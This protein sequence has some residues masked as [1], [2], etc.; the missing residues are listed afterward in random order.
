M[1]VI[2]LYSGDVPERKEYE[3]LIG[4][5][6]T[7][8]NHNHL[9]HD[10]TQPFL[11]AD[12]T[13]D[14]F[15]TEDVFEH[16]P[17]EKLAPV[18]NEIYRVLKPGGL[19]RLS[20]P[21]YGCDVLQNRSIKDERGEIVFDPGGGGT[22]DSP[23]HVWFPR[24]DTV[25]QL[26]TKTKFHTSGTIELLHYYNKDGTFVAK[27]IDYSKGP[28]MRTPDFDQRVKKPYRPMSLVIDLTKGRKALSGTKSI[29]CT[30]KTRK[31]EE[32]KFSFVMIVLNGMP[33][34]E[35]ALK[36]IYDFAH[37]IIIVEGS[38]E[39]CM[40]A[41]DPDGSST[42]GTVE[43]ITS[44]SDRQNKIKLIQG[45]WPEKCEMQNEAL[46][47]V[48]GDYVWLIDSDEVYKREDLEKIK[49]IIKA[50]PTVTQ[51]DFIP[52]NFW[53]GLDYIFVS[54]KFYEEPHHYRRLFKYKPGAV[55]T[56]H[57]PPTMFWPNS[58]LST[59]QMNLIDGLQTRQRGIILYHYSYVLERQVAQKMEY[60]R[61]C[62]LK[63]DR[64]SIDRDTWYNECFLR[65]NEQNRKQIEN[66]Y[67]VWLGDKN[68]HIEPFKGT[69]P[70]VM[71]EYARTHDRNGGA[72]PRPPVMQNL[73][74]A[75][76]E[77]KNRFPNEHLEMIETGTIR[78]FHAA[79][80]STY[81][82]SE[83]LGSQGRLTSVDISPDSIRIS[84]NFCW[85]APNIEWIQSDSVTYL[86]KLKDKKFH[87]AFLDSVNQKDFIFEEF[88]LMI[89]MM[90][91][92]SILIIDDSGI[93]NDGCSI[94]NGV[95]AQKGHEVWC[96]L[97]SCG[98]KFNIFQVPN[99]PG[100]QLKIGLGKENL[101]VIKNKLRQYDEDRFIPESCNLPANTQSGR[102]LQ[103]EPIIHFVYSGDPYDDNAIR[104]PRTITNKLFRFLKQRAEVKY[105]DWADKTSKVDVKLNDIIL[106]HPNPEEGT[107]IRRLFEKPCAAKYLIWPFHTRIPEINR[108]AKDVADVADKL[109]VISGPHWIETIDQTEYACW[110]EKI[111]R[112]DNAIDAEIFPLLKKNFNPVSKRGLF[113]FGRTG[114]E[115][116]T[117]QLFKLL[118][119]TDYPMVVA[120][121]YSHKDLQIIK[122]RPNTHIL[123]RIDWR[124]PQTTTFILN[125][126][127]FFVNMSVSDASP[128]TLLESM[129]LGLIPVTTPQCGYYYN[130]FLLLS[131]SQQEHNLQILHQAQ[132]L[133]D[134]KLRELQAQNRR[135]IE[136]EHSW[137][138]F[139]QTVWQNIK[140]T[141]KLTSKVG[142]RQNDEEYVKYNFNDGKNKKRVLIVRSDSIGDFVIFGG[143]LPYY[144][145]I[146]PNAQITIVVSESVAKLAEACLFIDEVITF[147][148]GKI[149][150][151]PNYAAEFINYVRDKQFDVAIC[152]A[153]SRDKVSEFIA[154][155]SG[156]V[157]KITC[158]GDTANLPADIIKANNAHYTK[159]VPM[160]EGIALETFRNE[161]F[162]KG[163]DVELDGPYRPTVWVTQADREVAE[164]LLN[165]RGIK[166]PIVIIPFVQLDI[167]NWPVKNWAKLISMYPDIPVIICG[168]AKDKPAAE[169]I[170][171]FANHPNIHN[172]CGLTTVRQ[173]AALI[174]KSRLS[175]SSESGAAHISAAANRP[176][177]VLIGGGHFGR[178]M[179]YSSQTKLVYNKMDCYNCNW[180]CKYGQDISCIATISVDMVERAV[181]EVFG[182]IRPVPVFDNNKVIIQA[183]KDIADKSDFLVSAIV[184]TYNSEKFIRGCLED[185]E[186]QTIADKLE[187]IVINSGS[188]ENE[189]TI[190][191]E[192]QQRYDNIKYIK[193]E[194]REG[195]YVAWNRAVQVAR[196]TF[197]TNANTDDRHR[198][199]ALEIMAE[200]LLAN[201][202]VALA[203]GD[204]ICTDTP[205]GTF[206]NHH[207]I[208]MARRAEYS[209][210][211]LL[212]GC[213]VGS[214][215]MWRKSLHTELGYFDDTLTCAGDWDFWLR[216]SIS[217]RY[218][219]KHIPEFLGLYYYNENGIEH[220]RKIHSLY[221]RYI[222]GKRYGNPYISVIPLYTSKDN[223]L[224]SVIMP[225]YNAAEYIEEAIES[226]LIQNYRNFE[227]IVVDDGSTDGTKDIV[228]SFKDERIKYFYH[229]NSGLAA[230]HNAGIKKS[231]GSFLIKLDHD[232]MMTADFI[233]KHLA[234]FEKHPDVDLVY[235]DDYLI[236]ENSNPIRVIERPE[237]TDRR[238]LIRDLFHCGFPVVPFRTCIRRSVFDKIGFFDEDL[239]I[240]EDYDMMRRFVKAGLKIHHLKGALYLRRM[241]R[242]SLSRNYSAQKA[243]SHFD[244]VKR[245]TDTFTYDE[246]FPDIE[247]DEIAPQIRQL[248]AKCLT[249]GTYLAIGQDYVKTNV[250]ECS[251]AA[252]DRACSELND[253][254]KMDPENQGLRQLLQKSKLIRARYTEAPQQVVSK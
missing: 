32:L 64:W 102:K 189:E 209:H 129:A 47:Y 128:T 68:S 120:G 235:C 171:S 180:Q 18:V 96:F 142:P 55:F 134:D 133:S 166:E 173:L 246:L 214:Q 101:K 98:A 208:E 108:Y 45:K 61:R 112:L 145:K 77:L 187:I 141:K 3:G 40:F 20:A 253:C 62:D 87:F 8:N 140:P 66:K 198:E 182:T 156:A 241:T 254:V 30:P 15:Q 243:K 28:V 46:K 158:S 12:N 194:Q 150:S 170:I 14:S 169:K 75:I 174:A 233:A 73:I 104:A 236:E 191:K 220:G 148:R 168:I 147:N 207:A 213:C 100:T 85:N 107:I 36:S 217:S 72:Y 94:D 6:L 44:F 135:I 237:Y 9:R 177:V 238:L 229:E 99:F 51:V 231:K 49:E 157:E 71:I 204:Q 1:P 206:A 225:A 76:D 200:T 250:P 216:I 95:P 53:K 24:I 143:A 114:L 222:V 35:Y 144:R 78:T 57:R 188:Q 50:D 202:D 245:F 137:D 199:D 211:R 41:A 234:E 83:A 244:V 19:F 146:Y 215:P 160:S 139:C 38:V 60:Y 181:N 210:E 48:N 116:G 185:L 125:N 119:K 251:K 154:I 192:F 178:F 70:E 176:H 175:I 155:N 249:A 33:L 124:H 122:N 247:W 226:V 97:K 65:W 163:L 190:V 67:P 252:F 136:R 91:E 82:I 227:L 232:D 172:L 183:K 126:C 115:K 105:Y 164:Q 123:G 193:T 195:I 248:H 13:V 4:L 23:G 103:A 196:G 138:K 27:P 239:L 37:E 34:I 223:P 86:A 84:K 165:R 167:R 39:K 54:D 221:E 117:A 113:V 219:F 59:E 159:I 31:N 63:T 179:P 242:D 186:N 21:D 218:K 161:E 201:P 56:S 118:C 89:P 131:L 203:Y 90:L 58:S 205:N 153:F 11:L 16:I 230:T 26:L 110:E 52:D 151:Q 88:R 43:F 92:N 93:T 212:F 121:D 69:H 22:P 111:V 109:F 197:L 184:S 5:S 42:D 74:D 2:R 127:D 79:C 80:S 132:Q 106:G 29:L 149:L 10:I 240:G 224:V 228:F 81:S 130:S 162:L 25:M 17:F 152:P 7:R